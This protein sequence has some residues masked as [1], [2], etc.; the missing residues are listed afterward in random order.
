VRENFTT[1]GTKDTKGIQIEKNFVIFEYF[2]VDK[3]YN[4]LREPSLPLRAS[5]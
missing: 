2:V 5:S 1:K 3:F 4:M